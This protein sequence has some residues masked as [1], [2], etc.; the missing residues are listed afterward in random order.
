MHFDADRGS[1]YFSITPVG[2]GTWNCFTSLLFAGISVVLYEGVPFFISPT[3]FWDLVDELKMTHVFIPTSIIDE[4]QKRGYIPTKSHS[5]KS[6]K[7]LMSGGSVMK[8]QLYDFFYSNI[9]KDIAFTSVFGS[10]EFLGSCFVFDFTLP[11]YKGEIPAI[12]LGV[13]V[14]VVDE[15]ADHGGG[16]MDGKFNKNIHSGGSSIS[17]A[18]LQ[19][20]LR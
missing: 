6:L 3:Y 9:E 7:V 20:A 17:D 4:L 16:L 14:E 13:N 2:W 19:S 5:L 12:S 1:V 8:S 11:I 10:T 15:T 18:E